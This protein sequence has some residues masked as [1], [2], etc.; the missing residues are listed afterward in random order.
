MRLSAFSLNVL[1]IVIAG[2]LLLLLF[3]AMFLK[4]RKLATV[5]AV[6]LVAFAAFIVLGRKQVTYSPA[7]SG[8]LSLLD[9]E[10]SGNGVTYHGKQLEII[11]QEQDSAWQGLEA[12]EVRYALPVL[13]W[14]DTG[15][16]HVYK[17]HME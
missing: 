14:F 1:I 9:V 4:K 16:P 5:F 13:K 7:P 2:I 3:F 17:L 10:I 11:G 6:I 8:N 12:F 15:L